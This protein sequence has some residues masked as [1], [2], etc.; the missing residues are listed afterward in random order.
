MH[1]IWHNSIAYMVLY[2]VSTGYGVLTKEWIYDSKRTGFYQNHQGHLSKNLRFHSR[3]FI[4]NRKFC[5]K[6]TILNPSLKHSCGFTQYNQTFS[7]SRQ[8][9]FWTRFS[10]ISHSTIASIHIISLYKNSDRVLG[11]FLLH[12]KV[13]MCDWL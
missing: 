3:R 2:D 8:F 12:I 6:F 7:L 1:H 13:V 5:T 9:Y 4:S 10:H 11:K